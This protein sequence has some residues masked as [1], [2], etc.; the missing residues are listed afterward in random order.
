M[1]VD[2]PLQSLSHLSSEPAGTA[3]LADD[4]LQSCLCQL[5][6]V[7]SLC[8]ATAVSKRWCRLSRDRTVWRR[9]LC[10]CFP[11]LTTAVGMHEREL[12]KKLYASWQPDQPTRP[13]DVVVILELRVDGF[14]SGRNGPP[15]SCMVTRT[16][17]LA[18]LKQTALPVTYEHGTPQ[19][20]F[21][22]PV[23]QSNF[24]A[25]SRVAERC[26]I[27]G[28]PL[29][30]THTVAITL[31]RKR[32]GKTVRVLAHPTRAHPNES[33]TRVAAFT[34]LGNLRPLNGSLRH[35]WARQVVCG[36]DTGAVSFENDRTIEIELDV[37]VPCMCSIGGGGLAPLGEDA[38]ALFDANALFLKI[39]LNRCRNF[40][41]NWTDDEDGEGEL[42]LWAE[43]TEVD[44]RLIPL[45]KYLLSEL[46]WS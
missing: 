6:Q 7:K 26:A 21:Q 46:P 39:S 25:V 34:W 11:G 35:S 33:N 36:P 28:G 42:C 2:D 5:D 30:G 19:C 31:L 24:E 40:E 13:Q 20:V 10:R 29:Y 8:S 3:K 17:E 18:S 43:P 9:L 38:R 14:G 4:D 41:T 12:I 1:R 16:F 32:D 44:S 15:P 23:E 45:D 37:S 22:L 27:N